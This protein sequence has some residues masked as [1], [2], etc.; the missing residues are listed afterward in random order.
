MTSPSLGQR[1]RQIRL[2]RGLTQIELAKGL[3]TPSMVSQ[4][5]SDRARPSY[6]V[7]SGIAARLDVPLEHLLKGVNFDLEYASKYKM[8][9]SMVLAKEYETAIQL[10][11]E[12]LESA[13]HRIPRES[14]QLELAFCHLEM[15]H[16]EDAEGILN[17]LYQVLSTKPEDPLFAVVMIHLG[18]VAE[19]KGEYPI[20]LF[21]TNRAWDELQKAEET[22]PDIQTKTLMQLAHLHEKIGKVTEAAA[23]FEN[24]LSL[25][26]TTD[27]ERGKTYLRLAEVYARLEKYEQA[28]EYAVKAYSLLSEQTNKELK[29]DM[30]HRLLMIRRGSSDWKTIVRDLLE[31]AEQEA[32]VG[33]KTKAGQ[34]YADIAL[35]CL[36]NNEFDESWAYA[37]KARMSL[38]DTDPAMGNVH[39]VL[40]F[41]Y[42]QRKDEKKGRKHLDNSVKIYKNHGK[43]AEL[44]EVT[45]YMCR[46][47]NSQGAQKE[48]YER[49]EQFHFY[50]LRKLEQ[51]GIV[52]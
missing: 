34:V 31:I 38:S 42:L 40:A 6:K 43:V 4:I 50:L 22:D 19:L 8:A 27:E 33:H 1:I 25:N 24:A 37:E 29:Q 5:E 44:E 12:L 48:A 2:N 41:I 52:M 14:L 30:Q 11:E 20:A 46:Y 15:G 39:R 13:P 45:L 35:V 26:Q 51:R 9:M 16:A 32:L 49:L 28:E 7:L 3:I 23:Y 21:H 17:Q 36:E 47:L 18:K 10:F